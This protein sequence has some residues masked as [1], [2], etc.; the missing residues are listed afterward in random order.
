MIKT[1]VTVLVA[2]FFLMV[3]IPGRAQLYVAVDG[4]DTNPGTIE[5]PLRT[6]TRAI[7]L[8]AADTTIYIRGGVHEY[9]TTI[10]L[11]KTGAPGKPIKIF[12]YPGE[13]PVIDFSSQPTAT[14]S[15]GFQISHNYWHVKGLEI[16]EAGD[17]G[18]YISG[19]YN[20]VEN[21]RIYR[22]EDTGLQISGGASHNKIINV[23]SY[24][25][26]DFTTAAE[27]ADGFAAKLSIGPGNE[28]HGCRAWLNADDG[29]DLYE[30]QNQVIIDN[31]WAFRNGINIWGIPG[32]Q[33][34]GNG[35]KL[36]GNYIQGPH[37]VTRSVAFDNKSKGFDQNN[38]TAG[39]TLYNNTAFRNGARNFSFPAN[40]ASGQHILKNN[41]AYTGSNIL[42]STT[43]LEANSW[44]SFTVR[45]TDFVSLDTSFVLSPR[46]SDSSLPYIELFRLRE[47]SPLVDAGVNVGMAF[48]GTAPDLGAFETGPLLNAEEEIFMPGE[49]ALYQNY[50]NPFNP[51]TTI[52][53]SNGSAGDYRL[54][55]F[56]L[57]GSRIAELANGRFEAGTHEVIYTAAGLSS[58][59]YYARL[60]GSG[61][62]RFIKLLLL[63]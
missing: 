19:W 41:I 40:P 14:T 32:Y 62:S 46:G 34:D 18:I 13:K 16:R 17:N 28:F 37:M 4:N 9:S 3:S 44:Q 56:D 11:N 63:K 55:I 57:A 10:R 47:T 35:F 49:F 6:I 26:V 58:G 38:N 51:S 59:I 8:A 20:V 53:F 24:E 43:L 45:D 36:G 5:L 15:R 61:S 21:C 60:S 42:S 29:W 1:N 12:A 33:G 39:V 27:N 54:E 25:N 7:Q 52:R 50:P 23:D 22:C 2:I 30:G 31:C 48:N